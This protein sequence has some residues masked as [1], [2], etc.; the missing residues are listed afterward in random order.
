LTSE[1]DLYDQLQLLQILAFVGDVHK[2]DVELLEVGEFEGRPDFHGLGELTAADLESLWD[3][4]RPVETELVA[5][6]RLG[7]DA[8]RA[9]EPT[10]VT[11][12]LERDTAA[13][14]FLDD[15]L[16]R[17]LEEL[18]DARAFAAAQLVLTDDGRA[19]L[20]GEADRVELLGVDRWVGGTHLEPGR[21]WRRDRVTG[22]ISSE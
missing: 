22:G 19:V 1:H 2:S 14:P 21:V 9:P 15:A 8:V 17:L 10:A 6:A 20:A 5:L 16:R 18:P 11:A 12:L 3:K 7:W 13:L 4:R